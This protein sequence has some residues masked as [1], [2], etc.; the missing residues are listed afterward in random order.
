MK[1]LIITGMFFYVA[2]ALFSCKKL[3]EGAKNNS[4]PTIS[5]RWNLVS[6]SSIWE[7]SGYPAEDHDTM[8]IGK[9][10]DF[11]DFEANGKLSWS[12]QSITS[13]S[14]KYQINSDNNRL[15]MF[16]Y[17]PNVSFNNCDCTFV[18]DITLLTD[19]KMI[20]TDGPFPTGGGIIIGEI[21]TFSR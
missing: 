14:S 16:Y 5:G 9:P 6:D 2:L 7:P 8:Y 19:H 10:A 11:Y 4:T 12:E 13:D 17:Y 1:K 21:M 20:L 15:T 3:G 18:Y